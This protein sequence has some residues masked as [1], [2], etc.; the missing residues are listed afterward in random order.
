MFYFCF[1]FKILRRW[2][3]GNLKFLKGCITFG[4]LFFTFQV[5]PFDFA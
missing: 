4:S 2:E 1:N 3:K 5:V